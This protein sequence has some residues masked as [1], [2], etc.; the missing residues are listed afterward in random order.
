MPEELELA[1]N[2]YFIFSHQNVCYLEFAIEMTAV[3]MA[4]CPKQ[5]TRLVYVFE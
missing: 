5:N 4:M 1:G 3:A 2:Q